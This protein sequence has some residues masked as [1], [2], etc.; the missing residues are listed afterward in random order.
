[1]KEMMAM[2]CGF[3]PFGPPMAFYDMVDDMYD[4][5]EGDRVDLSTLVVLS[6]MAKPGA[7]HLR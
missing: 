5:G 3:G 6:G 4:L 2:M 1:M 7:S